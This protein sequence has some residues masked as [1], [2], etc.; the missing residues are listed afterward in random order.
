MV[1]AFHTRLAAGL[2]LGGIA[3]TLITVAYHS[4]ELVA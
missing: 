3:G 2:F 4:L 1:A